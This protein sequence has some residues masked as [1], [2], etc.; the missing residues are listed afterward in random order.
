MTSV[1]MDPLVEGV[2]AAVSHTT[3]GADESIVLLAPQDL[4]VPLPDG[5][6]VHLH[7][8]VHQLGDTKHR[9]I[10]Y[11]LRATTRFREYF[12]PAVLPGL[13]DYSVAGP[14]Q[15]AD[16]LSSVRP[17]KPAVRDVIPLLLWHQQTEADQPF[18]LSRTRRGGVRIYLDRPWY[19][20]GNG[21]LLAVV[22]GP[23]TAGLGDE[24]SQWGADPVFAQLG[25]DARNDP[26]L[27][28]LFHAAGLDDRHAAGR[29]VTVRSGTTLVDLPGQP[30]VSLLGYQ[31][32]YSH[33]RGMWFV[34]V[35]LDPG[36]AF[37]PFVRLTVARW[38]PDSLPGLAL[39]PIVKCDFAQVLPQRTALLSRPDAGQA[40]IV[41]TGPFGLPGFF[42]VSERATP[43][44]RLGASRVMHARL[45]QRVPSVPTDLG[46]KTVAA[47]TLPV[48]GLDGA[49][50]SWEGTIDLPTP[51]PPQR[52]GDDPDWRVVVEEWE[53][54][55][56]DRDVAPAPFAI[57]GVHPFRTGTRI[58]YADHLP[59]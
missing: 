45:E 52:P 12:D 8:A 50:V 46:W 28:D 59:L 36:T 16:V 10:D 29:P 57:A 6:S 41:V 53:I 5:T 58:I 17:V 19:T 51:L 4:D 31:P 3:I 32:E 43:L 15:R 21:E 54:L 39:S 37:W 18:A 26:P 14:A 38:Q 55:P 30:A 44:E 1:R 13:D 7:A 2:Q 56:A 20:T 11:R 34:D 24:V 25:P 40:R 48:R 49:M 47:T 27:V 23:A 33:D 9:T 22:F 35:A 42:P